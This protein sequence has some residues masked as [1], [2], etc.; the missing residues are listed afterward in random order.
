MTILPYLFSRI[1]I[2]YYFFIS[3]VKNS[4]LLGPL[5]HYG[6]LKVRKGS[7]EEEIRFSFR[8]STNSLPVGTHVSVG[9]N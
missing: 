8:V 6:Q 5:G 2:L 4:H 1:Y 7:M 9:R 3:T